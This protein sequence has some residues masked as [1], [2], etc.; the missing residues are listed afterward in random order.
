L[1]RLDS[2]RGALSQT[3][4]LT[5][6]DR[7]NALTARIGFL[8]NSIV[9]SEAVGS[10]PS[11][12]EHARVV[13]SVEKLVVE[14]C[15][16]LQS[17]L[18]SWLQCYKDPNLLYASLMKEYGPLGTREVFDSDDGIEDNNDDDRMGE[19]GV[20]T[21]I[22]QSRSSQ[23][24]CAD[25]SSGSNRKRLRDRYY[26]IRMCAAWSSTLE[27]AWPSPRNQPAS[28]LKIRPKLIGFCHDSVSPGFRNG[29]TILQTLLEL[30][31]GTITLRDIP[32]MHVIFHNDQY[33]SVSNRRLC[34]YRLCD[35]LGLLP[36]NIVKVRLLSEKP[37]RFVQKFT[38]P[39]DGDWVRVRRDGRICGRTLE[40][41][42]F[43]RELFT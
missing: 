13:K 35:H 36:D 11:S 2:Y 25:S 4:R 19:P 28:F 14:C 21:T 40:E 7:C 22:L 15:P 18:P 24:P 16:E 12:A 37:R 9:P 8:R 17:S 10:S 1:G 34:L 39:C 3:E 31:N 26:K 5:E 6:I 30:V 27:V 43:G 23:Q 33:F 41:T 29:K 20:E 42:T 38:T 32:M